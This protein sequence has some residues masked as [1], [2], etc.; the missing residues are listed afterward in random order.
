MSS[1]IV[2]EAH[3]KR[4]ILWLEMCQNQSLEKSRMEF[5]EKC[6]IISQG[7]KNVE[8]RIPEKCRILSSRWK[9]VEFVGHCSV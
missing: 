7:W 8:C 9:N 4:Q 5:Q 2:Q 3:E 6:R 1:I